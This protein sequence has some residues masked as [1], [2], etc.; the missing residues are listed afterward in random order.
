MCERCVKGGGTLKA[1]SVQ[2]EKR[3]KAVAL[4]SEGNEEQEIERNFFL[5]HTGSLL[6]LSTSE[7]KNDISATRKAAGK[8]TNISVRFLYYF[9]QWS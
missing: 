3:R 7:K 2:E 5:Q 6:P 4:L 8:K 1:R 9:F